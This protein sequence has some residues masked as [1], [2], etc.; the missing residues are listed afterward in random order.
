MT[1]E[2]APAVPFSAK[3]R[4]FGMGAVLGLVLGGAGAGWTWFQGSTAL[5]AQEA[6]S[7]Q[8]IGELTTAIDL[9]NGRAHVLKARVGVA[10]ASVHLASQNYG[11]AGNALVAAKAALAKA[12]PK[13]AGVTAD[14]LKSASAALAAVDLQPAGDPAQQAATLSAAGAALDKLIGG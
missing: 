5:S 2:S 1:N 10:Q 6:A 4:L 11:E 3:A 12:E 14:G 8:R 13:A 7:T 9:A